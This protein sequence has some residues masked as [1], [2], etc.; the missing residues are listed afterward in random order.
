MAAVFRADWF[1]MEKKHR[2]VAE[3]IATAGL[4]GAREAV[5]RE[6]PDAWRSQVAHGCA[7]L[8][9][10]KY[11]GDVNNMERLRRRVVADVPAD[12]VDAVI[13]CALQSRGK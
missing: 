3:R 6:T 13:K 12:L 10:G 8:M 11:I 7:I 9:S 4:K 1:D 5:W 2:V